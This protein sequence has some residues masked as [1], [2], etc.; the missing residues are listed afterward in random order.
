MANKVHNKE[1]DELM[2]DINYQID[3]NP[4]RLVYPNDEERRKNTKTR[5]GPIPKRTK[6]QVVYLY[7]AGRTYREISSLTG[8][9]SASISKIIDERKEMQKMNIQWNNRA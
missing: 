1:L 4:D 3:A 8:V 5:R 2:S 7:N 9:S 6:D